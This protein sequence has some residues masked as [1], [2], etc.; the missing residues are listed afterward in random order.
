MTYTT[1]TRTKWRIR[2]G[3]LSCCWSRWSWISTRVHEYIGLSPITT[4]GS[5]PFE[6]N[7][8]MHMHGGDACM[9]VWIPF[10]NIDVARAS[11]IV[12]SPHTERDRFMTCHCTSYFDSMGGI[13]AYTCMRVCSYIYRIYKQKN[14]PLLSRINHSR[15]Q[16]KSSDG[17]SGPTNGKHRYRW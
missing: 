10:H 12:H 5:V 15:C 16:A 9:H 4:W 13:H 3:N 11:K 1:I 8:Y 2:H 6:N 14:N 17:P 7:H